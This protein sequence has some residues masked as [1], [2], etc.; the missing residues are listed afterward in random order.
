MEQYSNGYIKKCKEH[1]REQFR[2]CRYFAEIVA[3]MKGAELRAETK[4]KTKGRDA[5]LLRNKRAASA[6]LR[7]MTIA[8]LEVSGEHASIKYGLCLPIR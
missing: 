1:C 8:F 7:G 5:K 2:K 3:T 4:H 6:G